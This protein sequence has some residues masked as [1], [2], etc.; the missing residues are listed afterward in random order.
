MLI[1]ALNC[2]TFLSAQNSYFLSFSKQDFPEAERLEGKEFK[3]KQGVIDRLEKLRAKHIRK[4]HILAAIDS[5]SWRDNEALVYYYYGDEFDKISIS[6]KRDYDYIISKVPRVNER[7]ISK[8]P[9]NPGEVEILLTGVSNYLVNNGYP[10]SKVFLE[11]DEIQ[12]G[13]TIAELIIDTG[14]LVE[15]VEI[16]LKG[17]PKVNKKFLSNN[18]SIKE[19]DLYNEN[20]LRKIPSRI[21]QIQ[22]LNEIKPYELLFTEKGAELF[23][24]L[25]SNPVSLVNGVVGIQP[26][27]VTQENIITGDVRLKLQNVL[28]RGELLDINWRSL[29]PQTQDLKMKLNFPFLFNTPFGIDGSFDLYKQDSTFLTTN[30]NIGVQYFLLGGNYIKAF[31]EAD[32][33]NL[34][35]GASSLPNSSF[36]SV[37]TNRYGLGIFR[38]QLDYLPNPSKGFMFDLT[39]AVGRRTSREPEVDTSSISTTFSINL[40]A[41]WFIPI[42]R[43]NVIRLANQTSTYYAPTIFTNELYRFGGLLT[44]RGFDEEQLLATTMTTFTL[45]YRFL[46]D[47]NSHAFAFYDQSIYENNSN[48]YSAD[49]PFGFGAGFSFGTNIGIFSISYALGKQFDNPI[50]LRNGKVHFGYVA[51]F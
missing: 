35:S 41:E 24:Y 17:E 3:S 12:P 4:G 44:Q 10:F 38:R 26:D 39:G 19:G 11:M 45:E 2:S 28:K 46:V 48:G 8:L 22:F 31:Y 50:E 23:L 21:E 34:L 16:H 32:N 29:K 15:I 33:S 49:T 51:Y 13:T 43:R 25:E 40:T 6:Y 42:T 20:R 27:P 30:V 1:I 37:S 47:Q 18:I 36:S 9:F 14:P 5:I 7:A